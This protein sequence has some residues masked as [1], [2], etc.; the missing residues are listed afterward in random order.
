[1]H[2]QPRRDKRGRRIGYNWWR[3]YNCSL[4]LDATLT[5]ERDCEAVAIGYD[6]ETAE[7]AQ[8]TPRPT[9]KAFLL[10]NAGMNEPPEE[11]REYA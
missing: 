4:L 5:W 6:T 2:Q 9:L 3:E 10:A 1:V 8:H 11:E 7:Y